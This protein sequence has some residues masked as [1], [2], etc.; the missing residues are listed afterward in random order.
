M[1]ILAR[2]LAVSVAL[3]A[4]LAWLNNR[5]NGNLRFLQHDEMSHYTPPGATQTHKSSMN[6]GLF[7]GSGDGTLIRRFVN[8]D[9]DCFKDFLKTA[10]AVGW[11]IPSGGLSAKN[12]AVALVRP[13]RQNRHATLRFRLRDATVPA[14]AG[15]YLSTERGEAPK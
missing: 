1:R 7:P 15:M 3:L 12:D 6:G 8:C 5:P 9:Q 11:N 13:I 2:V 14:E 4:F 10:Q